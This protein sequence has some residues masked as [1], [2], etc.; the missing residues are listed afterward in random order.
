MVL[1]LKWGALWAWDPDL[2]EGGGQLILVGDRV[3][4]VWGKL[5]TELGRCY[6]KVLPAGRQARQ[7]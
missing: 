2:E 1:S 6:A 7:G 3:L 5:K 4:Q